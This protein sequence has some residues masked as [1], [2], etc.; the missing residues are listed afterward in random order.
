LMEGSGIM[1]F[2]QVVILGQGTSC[3]L[4]RARSSKRPSIL[5]A[6]SISSS[7]LLGKG[8]WKTK[9]SLIA[10]VRPWRK[11]LA[12]ASSFQLTKLWLRRNSTMNAATESVCC[13]VMSWRSWWVTSLG[14]PNIEIREL[15]K[16]AKEV[17]SGGG[18]VG[19]AR[20]AA[21]MGLNQLYAG[22]LR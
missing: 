13:R 21:K 14:F 5:R 3:S 12:R 4:S 10:P 6:A 16:V 15:S 8:F 7:R 11:A 19:I 1:E 22:P 18:D 20:Y 9:A 2:L 17:N